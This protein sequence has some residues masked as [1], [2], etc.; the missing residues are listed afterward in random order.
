[1]F[2]SAGV[3]GKTKITILSGDPKNI[4][5]INQMDSLCLKEALDRETI[6]TYN[7]LL[8]ASD[9]SLPEDSRLTSTVPLTVHIEDINDNAPVMTSDDIITCQEDFSLQAVVAVIRAVDLD[10]GSNGEI[11]YSLED[12]GDGTFRIGST[13]GIIYLQKHLDRES[14]D[15]IPIT[16]TLKDNGFPQLASSVNLTVHVEDINDNDP[17]FSRTFYHVLL[18]EDAPRGTSV[19]EVRAD[20]QDFGSNGLVRYE[21]S[22]SEFMV[23]SVL[24]II[25]VIAQLDREKISFYSLSV[26]AADKGDVQRSST[27]IVNITIVDKNDCAPFFPELLTLHVLENENPFQTTHQVSLIFHK[28]LNTLTLIVKLNMKG[29]CV[30]VF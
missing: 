24:G 2:I 21:I 23:D 4:F 16:V 20:D 6:A 26:T 3:N 25:S 18:N 13:T 14:E 11:L 9:C 5:L 17:V 28:H 1:M 27:A 22:D 7:L 19:L 15:V 29:V 30:C 8:Q 10:S 12:S